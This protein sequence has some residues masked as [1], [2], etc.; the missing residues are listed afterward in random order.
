MIFFKIS[1][2]RIVG[3]VGNSNGVIQAIVGNL[4]AA[5][6][7]IKLS[8]IA[9]LSTILNSLFEL[10]NVLN[11]TVGVN[12]YAKSKVGI[13]IKKSHVNARVEEA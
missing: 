13:A 12:Y 2:S 3:S 9:S 11:F 10:Q 4:W 5:L 1:S 6:L 8:T 7:S